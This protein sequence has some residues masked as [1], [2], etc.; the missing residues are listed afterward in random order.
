MAFK[1]I[2]DGTTTLFRNEFKYTTKTK[3]INFLLERKC[4]KM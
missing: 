4:L 3:K 1:K 2:A